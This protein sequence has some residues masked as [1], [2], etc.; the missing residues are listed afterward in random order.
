MRKTRVGTL[1]IG[2]SSKSLVFWE[3]K[4]ESVI[5][6]QKTSDSL[7]RSFPKTVKHIWKIW[8][9]ASKS[10]VFESYSPK[11]RANLG[12][13]FVKS[14]K[15]DSLTAAHIKEWRKWIAHSRTLTWAIMSERVKSERENS[16]VL[17]PGNF[18]PGKVFSVLR[19]LCHRR[20]ASLKYEKNFYLFKSFPVLKFFQRRYAMENSTWQR[21]HS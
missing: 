14:E 16:Q 12:C 17:T 15:S 3:Q 20:F 13:S 2:F 1:L 10:L 6:S 19:F 7:L 21:R 18:W 9:F 8:I 5:R 11:S 4:S